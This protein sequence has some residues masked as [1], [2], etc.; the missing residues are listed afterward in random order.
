MAKFGFQPNLISKY[1]QNPNIK[2]LL[3][4]CLKFSLLE[5]NYNNSGT[6]KMVKKKMA[7][8]CQICSG[9][10]DINKSHDSVNIFQSKTFPGKF[11]STYCSFV[12]KLSLHIASFPWPK[13]NIRGFL[14]EN[15]HT[16][17]CRQISMSQCPEQI[18]HNSDNRQWR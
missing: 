18:W 12:C 17:S 7:V 1:N 5:E 9:H 6:L 14:Q 11:E 16:E 13:V 8:S 15:L 3:K 2:T 4:T 10:C